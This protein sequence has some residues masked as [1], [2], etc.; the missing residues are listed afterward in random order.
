MFVSGAQKEIV[1]IY[2]LLFGDWVNLNKF[3][4]YGTETLNPVEE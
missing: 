2:K 3:I 4:L 1:R